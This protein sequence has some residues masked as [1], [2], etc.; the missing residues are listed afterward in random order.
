MDPYNFKEHFPTTN[1]TAE[2]EALLH[3]LKIATTL[4]I[5]WLRVLGDQQ[6]VIMFGWKDDDVLPSALQTGK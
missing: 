6:R 4:G 3:N 2:Y 5:R 1:N